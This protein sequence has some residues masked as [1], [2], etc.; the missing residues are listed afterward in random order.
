MIRKTSSR[1]HSFA[2]GK[3]PTVTVIK[4]HNNVFGGYTEQQ[5]E[6][7]RGWS[8]QKSPRVFPVQ[9][10]QPSGLPPTKMPLIPGKKDVLSTAAVTWD[11]HL[12]MAMI[13]QYIG[14][15]QRSCHVQIKLNISYQCPAGQDAEHF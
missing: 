1:F 12:V 14:I 6:K 3:G 2:T 4:C 10:C 13:F 9:S 15:G 7:S 8:L 5:W 11:R